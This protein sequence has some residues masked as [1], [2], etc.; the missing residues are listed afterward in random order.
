M[1]R[2]RLQLVI[3]NPCNYNYYKGE[4]LSGLPTDLP[5]LLVTEKAEEFNRKNN[6]E[7]ESKSPILYSTEAAMAR[8]V[9]DNKIVKHIKKCFTKNGMKSLKPGRQKAA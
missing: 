8:S 2:V 5:Y 6:V 3:T 7:G 4:N 1:N 9:L